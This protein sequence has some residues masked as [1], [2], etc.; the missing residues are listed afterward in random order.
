MQL[1]NLDRIDDVVTPMLSAGRVPG[2]G[3]AIV[4][5]GKTVFAKGYGVSDV[6]ATRA[7]TA[8]TV[9]PIASTTKAI[10]ATLIGMLV[11][12]GKLPGTH[13]RAHTCHGCSSV[14]PMPAR[15]SRCAISS[16]CA[17][18]CRVTISYGLAAPFRAPK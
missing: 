14:I 4:A 11:D 9:Y 8:D 2:A 15:M 16:R 17:P 1:S 12:E 7:A 13:R 18:A 10:N 3:L 6:A 5:G